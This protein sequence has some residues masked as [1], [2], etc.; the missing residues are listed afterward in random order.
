VASGY[1]RKESSGVS[2]LKTRVEELLTSLGDSPEAVADSLRAKG[3]KGNRDDGCECP[4]A[5]IITAE[6]PEARDGAD[7][8]D[9]TG[10]WFV[11]HGYIRTPA[12]EI[13]PGSAVAEFIQ[14]FDDG[15]FV[16][17]HVEHPYEDLEER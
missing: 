16:D 13:D 1:H 11:T 8:S 7:W 15:V 5:N 17:G 4:I 12:G 14:V 6:F 10:A 9:N 3:I 2:D